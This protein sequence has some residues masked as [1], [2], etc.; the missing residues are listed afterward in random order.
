MKKKFKW[1][2]AV[3]SQLRTHSRHSAQYRV[4]TIITM[5]FMHA[6]LEP[7]FKSWPQIIPAQI[8]VKVNLFSRHLHSQLDSLDPILSIEYR[9]I[10]GITAF[11]EI[12]FRLNQQLRRHVFRSSAI[13]SVHTWHSASQ[14]FEY[15]KSKAFAPPD[16][17]R[18]VTAGVKLG[19][20]VIVQQTS[21]DD[22]FSE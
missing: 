15:R 14:R 13:V 3:A 22:I 7:R 9:T 16:S 21:G 6:F 12:G 4:A 1:P 18:D 2:S 17:Q 19:H 20:A 10:G 5:E 8:A 11:H